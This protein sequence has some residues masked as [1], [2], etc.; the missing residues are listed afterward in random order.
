MTGAVAQ[1]GGGPPRRG[2]ALGPCRAAGPSGRLRRH[3][4]LPSQPG[5]VPRAAS[6]CGRTRD[7]VAGPPCNGW[8]ASGVP[9]RPHPQPP[10]PLPGGG[11]FL[12][13]DTGCRRT[14]RPHP[15]PAPRAPPPRALPAGRLQP[16]RSC[17]SGPQDLRAP[18]P[19]RPSCPPR[20]GPAAVSGPML[21]PAAGPATPG[22]GAGGEVNHRDP[23]GG[24]SLVPAGRP[25]R[26]RISGPK[27]WR[28]GGWEVAAR[29]ADRLSTCAA[30]CAPGS[31]GGRTGECGGP[32][33]SP[34]AGL[35]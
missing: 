20:T 16:R 3:A 5:A 26:E 1:R 31:A 29:L 24:P 22:S 15:G 23:G 32:A 27:R 19:A 2:A 7:P 14:A 6:E 33:A 28:S 8:L 30:G 4:A 25:G 10:P 18:G 12:R 9:S 21:Q 35:A 17:A 11:A 34:R 13:Q